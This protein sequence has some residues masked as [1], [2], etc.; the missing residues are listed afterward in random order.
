M[1]LQHKVAISIS[2]LKQRFVLTHRYTILQVTEKTW[3]ILCRSAL[4]H[5]IFLQIYKDKQCFCGCSILTDC[6]GFEK[7]PF[8]E[9]YDLELLAKGQICIWM[10]SKKLLSH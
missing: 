5:V 8:C 2:L 4:K 6:V 10:R 3:L 1:G 7:L 9:L